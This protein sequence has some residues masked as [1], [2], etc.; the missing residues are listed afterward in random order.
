MNLAINK[1]DISQDAE[2][3][4]SLNALHKAAGGENSLKPSLFYRSNSFKSVVEILKAQ[5]RAFEPIVKKQGKYGGTWIC[6]ELVLKYAMWVSAEFEVKVMQTFLAITEK[7]DAPETMQALNE[8]TKK[9]EGDK[10]LASKCGQLLASYK[11]IKKENTDNWVSGV[12]R[13]QIELGL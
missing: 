2:G 5:N 7:V 6:R 1:T 13:V 11:R 4:Y 8:L 3:R 10:E 9:I 12:K